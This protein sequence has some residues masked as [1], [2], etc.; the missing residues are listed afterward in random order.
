MG[1]E[2]IKPP[3]ALDIALR[4]CVVE[5]QQVCLKVVEICAGIQDVRV[6]EEDVLEVTEQTRCAHARE[7]SDAEREVRCFNIRDL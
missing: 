6:V 3:R 7:N 5:L 1:A 2:A 4:D